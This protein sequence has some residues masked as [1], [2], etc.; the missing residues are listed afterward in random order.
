MEVLTY[1]RAVFMFKTARNGL[2]KLENETY[3]EREGDTFV[4]RFWE[5]DIIRIY[6]DGTYRLRHGGYKTNTTQDR[7][8]RYSPVKVYRRKGEWFHPDGTPFVDGVLVDSNG[9]IKG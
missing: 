2:R 9:T 5:V 3:L 1:E 7:I 8:S 6:A 4:I